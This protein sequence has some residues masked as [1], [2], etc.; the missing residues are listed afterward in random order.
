MQPKDPEYTS[1][2]FVRVRVMA[3]KLTGCPTQRYVRVQPVPYSSRFT[4][5]GNVVANVDSILS[6]PILIE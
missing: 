6:Q 1:V 5:R 2:R 4:N 3:I